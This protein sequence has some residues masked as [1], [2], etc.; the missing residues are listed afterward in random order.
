MPSGCV[1]Y[2]ANAWDMVAGVLEELMAGVETPIS[3]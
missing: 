3:A 2:D 1:G